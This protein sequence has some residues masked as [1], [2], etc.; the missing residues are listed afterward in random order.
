[1]SR[2][3]TILEKARGLRPMIIDL[4]RHFHRYPEMALQEIKTAQKIEDVLRGLGVETKMLVNR[5]GVLGH[6]RGGRP[7]KTIAL[8]ADIDGLPIQEESDVSYRSQN[9]G[10]MHACGHDAHIAMLLGAAKIL[11]DLRSDMAGNV[12]FLFQ[13]AEETGEGAKRMVEEGCLDGVDHVFG[14]HVDTSL[15]TGTLGYRSGAMMAAGD[16]FDVKIT[17]KGGHGGKPHLAIDPIV[18]AAN[19]IVAIQAVVSRE[20]DPLESAVVSIC[21]MEAGRAYNIIPEAAS[22][23]GTIRSLHRELRDYLPKRMREVIDGVVS[24]F[25]GRFEFNLMQRFP[26]TINDERMTTFVARV[27]GEVLGKEKVIE[28]RPQMASEDFSCYL[29]KVPGCFVF[30]GVRNREK[31]IT[32]ANH[33]PRFDIDEEALPLGTALHVA[34]ALDYLQDPSRLNAVTKVI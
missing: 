27:A 18:M 32:F 13:P 10:F 14:L 15:D 4:R 12:T 9:L 29:E 34:I 20:I 16:F 24:G 30:L 25:R 28:K 5:A 7:G 23:G 8:R 6:L 2:I 33:H 26:L 19:A 21:K 11:S 17:G 3:D 31:G 1:M 22:F